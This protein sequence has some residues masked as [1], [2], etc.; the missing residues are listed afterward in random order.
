LLI[1]LLRR[2]LPKYRARIAWVVALQF[3]QTMATLYLP[4]LN[5]DITTTGWSR[6]TN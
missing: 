4:T 3:L 6:D 2:H 5:A 1:K